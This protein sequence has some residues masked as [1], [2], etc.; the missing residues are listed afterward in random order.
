MSNNLII[1]GYTQ[2]LIVYN[3]F[4]AIFKG[5]LDPSIKY[6]NASTTNSLNVTKGCANVGWL[7][8]LILL[9]AFCRGEVRY[10]RK[11]AVTLKMFRYS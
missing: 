5:Y 4:K 10:G 6:N 7:G 9:A 1:L 2:I 8:F 11:N 3:Y